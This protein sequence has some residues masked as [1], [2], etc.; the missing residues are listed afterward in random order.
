MELIQDYAGSLQYWQ[1]TA[2]GLTTLP[3]LSVAARAVV[4]VP[5]RGERAAARAILLRQ[6]E[7]VGCRADLDRVFRG[8][9]SDRALARVKE[10]QPDAEAYMTLELWIF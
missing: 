10:A 6:A 5:E 9:E 7:T 1:T 4:D 3:E 8:L 2:H